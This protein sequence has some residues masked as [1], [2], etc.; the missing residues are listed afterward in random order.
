MAKQQTFLKREIMKYYRIAIVLSAAALSA[1]CATPEKMPDDLAK[2]Q[3]RS[4]YISVQRNQRL[5]PEFITLFK[6]ETRKRLPNTNVTVDENSVDDQ[7]VANADWVIALRA[8]RIKP[9]YFNKPSDN[10]T[11]NGMTDYVVGAAVIGTFYAPIAP[12][13]Y[14]TDIDFLEANVRNAESKTL[15]TYVAQ[16]D[17]EGWMFP[18]PVTAIKLWLT[19]KDQPQQ[20]WL[21]LIDTLYDKMLRDD[22][23]NSGTPAVAKQ[24]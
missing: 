9:N 14:Q 2:S 4:L 8:T 13:I 21:D 18:I 17:G 16:Q 12:G 7:A 22:V 5:P 1:G 23:F 15:K 11:L 19:G 6:Q 24:E 3:P 20:I 10:A